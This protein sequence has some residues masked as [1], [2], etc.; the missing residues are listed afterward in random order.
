MAPQWFVAVAKQ[1]HFSLRKKTWHTVIRESGCYPMPTDR[2][3]ERGTSRLPLGRQSLGTRCQYSSRQLW[4]RGMPGHSGWQGERKTWSGRETHIMRL[5]CYF[6]LT[7]ESLCGLPGQVFH[8]NTPLCLHWNL[9][10]L[11]M[12]LIKLFR[13]MLFFCS[14][15]YLCNVIPLKPWGRRYCILF[16]RWSGKPPDWRWRRPVGS[17]SACR[18]RP[19]RP[20]AHSP[21]ETPGFG[22]Y[23]S[24]IWRWRQSGEGK[25]E[26]WDTVKKKGRGRQA[27]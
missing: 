4:Y 18:C 5:G 6:A 15:V 12:W 21:A 11:H 22:L 27:I 1:K 10:I 25:M 26:G 23:G 16:S 8:S 13:W 19:L 14:V 24:Y 3:P 17:D 7:P 20:A 2:W 9:L